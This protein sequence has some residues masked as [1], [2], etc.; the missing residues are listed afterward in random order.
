MEQL[1]SAVLGYKKFCTDFVT[2]DRCVLVYLKKPWM[3]KKV[4]DL[5]RER[6]TLSRSGIRAVNSTARANLRRGIRE[7]EA[8][9]GRRIED[10]FQRD[11]S[12]LVWQGGPSYHQ[13]QTEQPVTS[14][15]VAL[16]PVVVLKCFERQESIEP[17]NKSDPAN[18]GTV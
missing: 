8:A 7:A 4:Q 11:H 16:I 12:R 1:T 9:Y 14:N 5:L 10:C 2:V 15:P 3:T 17:I 18:S 6:I 13:L